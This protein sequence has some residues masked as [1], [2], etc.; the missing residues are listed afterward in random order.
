MNARSSILNMRGLGNKS[1]LRDLIFM[2]IEFL[3]KIDLWIIFLVMTTDILYCLAGLEFLKLCER[4]STAK[5]RSSPVSCDPFPH[6]D[7]SYFRFGSP[8]TRLDSLT[9]HSLVELDTVPNVVGL[10]SH[11]STQNGV[12][13]NSQ[14]DNRSIPRYA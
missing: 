9:Q 12:S 13:S 8:W 10:I 7:Q 2:D 1:S 14:C 11:Y 3:Y 6:S 5:H 4:A